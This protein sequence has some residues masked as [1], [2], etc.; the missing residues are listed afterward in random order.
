MSGDEPHMCLAVGCERSPE[1]VALDTDT[2]LMV[3][4]ETTSDWDLGRVSG[5][6]DLRDVE[7]VRLR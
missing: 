1:E 3:V 5:A 6:T 2:G 7:L 4:V